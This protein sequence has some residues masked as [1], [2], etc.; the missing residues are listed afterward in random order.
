MRID[1]VNGEPREPTTRPASG[2]VHFDERGWGFLRPTADS[3]GSREDVYVS[4]RQINA[5]PFRAGD[6]VEGRSRPPKDDESYWALIKI[7]RVNANAV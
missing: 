7:T 4:A 5:A 3:G 6:R 1:S 2:Y